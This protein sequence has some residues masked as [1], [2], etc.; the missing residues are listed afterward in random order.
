[1]GRRFGLRDLGE[2]SVRAASAMGS[3]RVAN[4]G[5]MIQVGKTLGEG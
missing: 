1:M 5:E 2:Q 4:A 3:A